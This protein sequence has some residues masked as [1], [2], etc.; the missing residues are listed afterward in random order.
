MRI[1]IC[2]GTFDPFHRGHLEPVLAVRA[3]MGWDRILFIPAFVQPFKRDRASA[4][5][6]HRFAMATL[7]TLAH[8]EVFVDSQ[9]LERGAVSYTVDT[10]RQLRSEYPDA[11]FD[12][13]VGDDNLARLLEWKSVEEIFQL[14]NFAVLRR[15]AAIVDRSVLPDQLR[16]RIAD[17]SSRPGNGAVVFASNPKVVVSATDI[18]MRVAA[19]QPIDELVDPHVS[20]Y[21]HHYALYRKGQA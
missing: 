9:E 17:A 12:W 19:G 5:G 20:R 1:A 11:V 15:D 3:E 14:A 10:L 6:Y 7:A 18:R 16:L 13:V 8:E 21:I 4:S 2:G